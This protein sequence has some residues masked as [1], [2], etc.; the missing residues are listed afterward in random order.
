[1]RIISQDGLMSVDMNGTKVFV[2]AEA[3]CYGTDAHKGVLG[4]YKSTERARDVLLEL[5]KQLSKG[6]AFMEMP[7]E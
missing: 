6:K 7:E 2:S 3:I 5:H 1:M 4:Y